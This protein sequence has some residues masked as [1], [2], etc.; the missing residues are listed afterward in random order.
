M[1]S[2]NYQFLSE[3]LGRVQ[4]LRDQEI[5]PTLLPLDFGNFPSKTLHSNV[6]NFGTPPSPPLLSRRGSTIWSRNLWMAPFSKVKN[7]LLSFPRK[8]FVSVFS[9]KLSFYWRPNLLEITILKQKI[10]LSRSSNENLLK[11]TKRLSSTDLIKRLWWCLLL[12]LLF[13]GVDECSKLIGGLQ[14]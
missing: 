14:I 11:I 1:F 9:M 7:K 5:F 2:Q 4:N 6:K 8:S 13:R 10:F 3:V 12:I